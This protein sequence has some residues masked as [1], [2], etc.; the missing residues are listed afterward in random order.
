M[1]TLMDDPVILPSSGKTM[2]RQVIKRHLLNSQTD[3]FNRQ[4]LSE[5]DLTSGIISLKYLNN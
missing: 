2:D 5:E 4:P 1:D 3:P